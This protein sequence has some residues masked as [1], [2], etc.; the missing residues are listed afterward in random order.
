MT[1]VRYRQVP[2]AEGVIAKLC[3]PQLLDVGDELVKRIP[4][5]V[6]VQSG[7]SRR[8]FREGLR[9]LPLSAPSFGARVTGFPPHWHW[10]EF[11]TRWNPPYA[12]IRRAI[13][14]LGAR[15]EKA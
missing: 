14:Q 5:N 13:E 2:D 4:A 8:L 3:R 11:G 12:P 15:Y 1:K 6:P 10:F 9:R 7:T